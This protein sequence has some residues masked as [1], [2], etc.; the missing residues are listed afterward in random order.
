MCDVSVLLGSLNPAFGAGFENHD[1]GLHLMPASSSNKGH[2]QY[3]TLTWKPTSVIGSC[4]TLLLIE[5]K[6]MTTIRQTRHSRQ[7]DTLQLQGNQDTADDTDLFAHVKDD[8]HGLGPGQE[9]VGVH[10][11][12]V[13]KSW[14]HV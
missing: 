1:L 10:C 11:D 6:Q 5:S 9:G 14:H 7:L 4:N 12:V 2:T 8:L 13:V 3:S